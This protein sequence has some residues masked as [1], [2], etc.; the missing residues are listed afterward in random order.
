MSIPLLA[1]VPNWYLSPPSNTQEEYFSTG[2]GAN[3]SEAT[4][5]A[6]SFIAS[7]VSVTVQSSF[8]QD[9]HVRQINDKESYLSST[10]TQLQS[11]THA[12]KFNNFE[13]LK[14]VVIDRKVYVLLSV[15]KSQWING[16]ISELKEL[17]F[18]LDRYFLSL[19]E[20]V[21]SKKIRDSLKMKKKIIQARNLIKIISSISPSSL[22]VSSHF[23]VYQRYDASIADVL[24]NAIVYI[25]IKDSDFRP[26]KYAM[27]NYFSENRITTLEKPIDSKSLVVIS[28]Q[29]NINYTKKYGNFIIKGNV[30]YIVKDGKRI[31]SSITKQIIQESQ[32]DFSS[33]QSD[34]QVKTEQILKQE[35]LFN[36]IG[37]N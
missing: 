30:S 24:T 9:V 14:N 28:I 37:L 17:N 32:V 3:I 18:T 26:I 29:G 23:L 5:E 20:Q 35:G 33:T 27:Q 16:K 2:A 4:K 31:T 36:Y 22:K 25:K 13:V 8:K 34:L 15:K 7:Q 6:L 1:S 11:S 10:Q 21:M 12:L 19:D